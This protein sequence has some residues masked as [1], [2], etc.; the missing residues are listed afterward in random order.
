MPDADIGESYQDQYPYI[1]HYTGLH[2]TAAA[3][4]PDWALMRSNTRADVTANPT[5]LTTLR[6]RTYYP[7]PR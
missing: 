2:D 5:D 7:P 4:L 6:H 3:E 1:D